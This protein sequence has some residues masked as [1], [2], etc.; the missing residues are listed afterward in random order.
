M[1]G[2]HFARRVLECLFL[3]IYSNSSVPLSSFLLNA[4]HFWL[5]LGLLAEYS[6]FSP[7]YKNPQ[8]SSVV[9]WTLA[10]TFGLTELL[11]SCCHFLLMTLRSPK[12]PV[13]R[14]PRVFLCGKVVLRL[15]LGVVRQLFVGTDRH[16]G[17]CGASEFVHG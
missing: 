4:S 12:E 11:N 14:I 5:L 7:S 16:L 8:W 10:V 1:I 9:Y 17:I 2:F 3:H 15:F 6:L 13:Y